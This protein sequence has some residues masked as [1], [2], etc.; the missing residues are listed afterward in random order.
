MA[1]NTPDREAALTDLLPFQRADFEGI[2]RAM[3]GRIIL[4][5]NK[6]LLCLCVMSSD[7]T[8]CFMLALRFILAYVLYVFAHCAP[9]HIRLLL[10]LLRLPWIPLIFVPACIV[11]PT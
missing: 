2:Y 11:F 1:G 5:E 7:L 9:L 10:L 6:S 3:D 8:T 4:W